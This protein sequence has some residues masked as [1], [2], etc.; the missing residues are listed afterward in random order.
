MIGLFI[1]P[2]LL[3]TAAV[4]APSR[5]TRDSTFRGD[6]NVPA[7]AVALPSSLDPF[8]HAPNLFLLGVGV[9]NYTCNSAGSFV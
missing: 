4:A 9:Q 5:S 2:L 7:S 1:L 8:P 3:A 6:C